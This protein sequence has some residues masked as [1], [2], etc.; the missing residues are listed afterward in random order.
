MLYPCWS[1]YIASNM[2]SCSQ[3][4]RDLHITYRVKVV[5]HL[6]VEYSCRVNSSRI[7]E[8]SFGCIS[9]SSQWGFLESRVEYLRICSFGMR[10]IPCLGKFGLKFLAFSWV[11]WNTYLSV[12]I[13]N[14][15]SSS[16]STKKFGII[17]WVRIL[18][19]DFKLAIGLRFIVL[20]QV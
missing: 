6:Y 19:Q 3:H 13:S 12:R 18:N 20:G 14:Q 11:S 16:I 17:I 5:N 4:I 1:I 2:Q 9:Q 8:A 10:A 15:F 7:C